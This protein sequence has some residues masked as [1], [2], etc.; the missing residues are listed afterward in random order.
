MRHQVLESNEVPSIRLNE[1]PSIALNEVPSIALN[2]VPSTALNEG[3]RSIP[4]AF[5]VST[6]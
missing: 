3:M 6:L 4:I 2:E 5:S 1:V